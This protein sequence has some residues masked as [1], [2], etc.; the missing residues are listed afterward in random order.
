MSPAACKI[1]EDQKFA[2]RTRE[3][4]RGITKD[5]EEWLNIVKDR[6]FCGGVP[7]REELLRLV[8]TS[9]DE[10]W[11]DAESILGSTR[12]AYTLIYI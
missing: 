9:N 4:R 8:Y 6:A 10:L 2:P 12:H 3:F 1:E 5:Y 7:L 11:H